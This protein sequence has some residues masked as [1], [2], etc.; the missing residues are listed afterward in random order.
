MRQRLRPR[1][2]SGG[3]ATEPPVYPADM[4]LDT[5]PRCYIPLQVPL[6]LSAVYWSGLSAWG[7][8]TGLVQCSS[9]RCALLGAHQGHILDP[10]GH[11]SVTA[12]LRRC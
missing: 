7:I 6:W 10:V 12:I 8:V 1:A 2:P 5:P 3:E 11:A 9:V 4:R